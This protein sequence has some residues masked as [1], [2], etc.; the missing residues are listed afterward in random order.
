MERMRGIA[1]S[2]A[3]S[4]YG[5]TTGAGR[6][7]AA[8]GYMPTVMAEA[9][10]I[11]K[12]V[13][14]ARSS[15]RPVVIPN[16]AFGGGKTGTMVANTGEHIVKNYGGGGGSA[17]FNR[18]MA[19]GG[20]PSGAQQI[21]GAGGF[22]PN[23]AKEPQTVQE[24]TAYWSM[25]S[26][27]ARAAN[28]ASKAGD[29]NKILGARAAQS[30][31]SEIK[32]QKQSRT[33]SLDGSRLGLVSVSGAEAGTANAQATGF[34]G[35]ERI[36]LDKNFKDGSSYQTVILKGIQ[37]RSLKNLDTNLNDN[38]KAFRQKVANKLLKPILELSQELMPGVFSGNDLADRSAQIKKVGNSDPYIF[39][40]SVL[41]GVFE[42]EVYIATSSVDK[43]KSFNDCI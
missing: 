4:V 12:G 31:S 30:K 1:A 29:D 20:L 6:P 23:F 22:I 43:M 21:R 28:F 17:I 33:L 37:T 34:K 15:D 10:D 35:N 42:S 40:D 3:P 24:W 16:F 26:N 13:G 39:S 18:N 32:E 8:G 7:R 5:A 41:G 36:S 9:N 19:K 11:N 2:I 25:G 38:Q 14:G 27:K